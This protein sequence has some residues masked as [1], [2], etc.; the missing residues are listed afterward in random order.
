MVSLVA[1]IRLSA[2]LQ[3]SGDYS[4]ISRRPGCT[5][6]RFEGLLK[7]CSGGAIYVFCKV[8]IKS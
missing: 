5:M 3:V 6:I 2:L 1:V 7:G 4:L 8:T